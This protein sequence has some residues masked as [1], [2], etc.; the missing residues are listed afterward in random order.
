M[1]YKLYN[2]TIELDFNEEKHLYTV[3]DKKVDGTTGVL[4]VINKPALIGWAVNMAVAYFQKIIKA[5]ISYDEIQLKAMSDG[6]KSCHRIKRDEA[7]DIGKLVHNWIEDY[8]KGNKPKMLVNEKAKKCIEK[9]LEWEKKSKIEFIH[10]EKIVYSKKYK[11]AGTLDFIGKK[12]G[13]IV[14]GD[15]KTS[16]GIWNEMWFQT[17]GYQQ[18]YLEEFPKEKIS[19]QIIV[20]LGKDGSFEVKESKPED[21]EGNRDAFLAALILHRRLNYLKDKDYKEKNEKA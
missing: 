21:Y 19:H 14:L 7:G 12:G 18:A 4:G 13:K 9:F 8:I 17:S 10:S 5:G 1:I 3:N 16:S 11:Y 6:M 15:F 2:N 20:R